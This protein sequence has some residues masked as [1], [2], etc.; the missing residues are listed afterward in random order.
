MRNITV[1]VPDEVYRTAR[2]RAAELGKSVSALVG[3]F[4]TSL[5]D[6]EAEFA[7]LLAQQQRVQG[8]IDRFRAADRLS[9]DE[10]HDRA[11][12]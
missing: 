12:R 7:R 2:I 1:A 3:E 4:L 10:L 9:R 11:I 6:R 5:S 8:E